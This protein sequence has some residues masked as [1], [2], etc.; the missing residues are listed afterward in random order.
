MRQDHKRPTAGSPITA[1]VLSWG[2]GAVV[3][4][5]F[6]IA[7]VVRIDAEWVV[8]LVDGIFPGLV[9]AVRGQP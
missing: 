3:F 8:D 1:V 6:V 5:A 9:N 4:V 7:W 2:L